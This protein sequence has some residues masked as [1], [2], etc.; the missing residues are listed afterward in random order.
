MAILGFGSIFFYGMT[1]S[2]RDNGTPRYW[3]ILRRE[4]C[5][6]CTQCFRGRGSLLGPI[7]QSTEPLERPSWQTGLL[8][9]T[10]PKA[11]KNYKLCN[12]QDHELRQ[13]R[14]GKGRQRGAGVAPKVPMAPPFSS[15]KS[16]RVS[17]L[18]AW[19]PQRAL[20]HPTCRFG[21]SAE[22]ARND[23]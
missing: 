7:Q 17:R 8:D 1:T 22:W 16:S 18:Q 3:K 19:K 11:P 23:G 15:R 20:T 12:R 9:M 4:R 5:T 21:A 13:I 10:W 2:Y 6:Q 14:R